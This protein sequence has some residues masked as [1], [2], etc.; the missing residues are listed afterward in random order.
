MLI[1][2]GLAI[3]IVQFVTQFGFYPEALLRDHPLSQVAFAREQFVLSVFLYYR[4]ALELSIVLVA[5]P[6]ARCRGACTLRFAN[7]CTS[8]R[9]IVLC[10]VVK[11]WVG[12][13]ALE[14]SR[15]S[16]CCSCSPRSR[17][18]SPAILIVA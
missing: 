9:S 5:E 4:Q 15:W 11:L 6:P 3:E 18:D 17:P 10:V 16:C 1:S 12:A 7:G 13:R 2:L 14:R 8:A